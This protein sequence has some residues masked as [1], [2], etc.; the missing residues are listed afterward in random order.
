MAR[1]SHIRGALL[2]LSLL[3]AGVGCGGD[4]D[5]DAPATPAAEPARAHGLTAEQASAVAAVVGDTKITAGEVA[6]AL[7]EQSPY[8]RAR[9]ATPERKREFLDH[10]VELELLVEEATRRGYRD[11][12]EVA[13]ARREALIAELLRVEVDETLDP[14]AIDDDAIRAFYEAHPGD[15]HQPEQMRASHILFTDR[16]SA[17]RTLR[18]LQAAKGDMALFR[19]LA[20]EQSADAETKARGGDLRF[21]SRPP[22]DAAAAWSGPPRAVALAAFTLAN[23][24][25][26]Y[27]EVIESPAGFHVVAR[28]AHR[29]ALARTLEEVDQ[30]IRRR[31]ERDQREAA[32]L[33]LLARLRSEASVEINEEAL[34]DVQIPSAA[35]EATQ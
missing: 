11:R 6:E 20:T 25:D 4:D 35:P 13:E 26:V 29:L 10:L 32:L 22:E 21:F 23:N 31:L 2:L 34:A 7:D 19:R 5:G 15:F 14:A 28:T 9:Y 8:L 30:V 24:G 12:P 33:A 18:R 1:S 17:T 3:A 27:G 16:A